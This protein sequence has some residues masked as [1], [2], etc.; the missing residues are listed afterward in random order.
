M[1]NKDFQFW[2]HVFPDV[3]GNLDGQLKPNPGPHGMTSS[4]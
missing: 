4:P 2:L 1:V 3:T